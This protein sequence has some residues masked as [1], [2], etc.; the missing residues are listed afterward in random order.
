MSIPA[1]ST[2]K[3]FVVRTGRRCGDPWV[4]VHFGQFRFC[5]EGDTKYVHSA[6]HLERISSDVRF[7]E[8]GV[9]LFS[10]NW[11]QVYVVQRRHSWGPEDY[12]IHAAKLFGQKGI[13]TP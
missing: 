1:E 13:T 6:Q 3:W 9:V 7:V 4:A 5:F 8:R 11:T 10:M 12:F 2:N